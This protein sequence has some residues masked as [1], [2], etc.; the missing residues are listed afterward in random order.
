[1]RTTQNLR[2]QSGLE[3]CDQMA[4]WSDEM[5]QGVGGCAFALVRLY[6][7][8]LAYF[9]ARVPELKTVLDA[10]TWEGSCPFCGGHLTVDAVSAWWQCEGCSRRGEP[11]AME[12]QLAGGEPGA[13]SRCCATVSMLMDGCPVEEIAC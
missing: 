1:M 13:W 8:H 9:S 3:L 5:W 10:S 2:T 7:R 6:E 11:L 4:V 12:Y